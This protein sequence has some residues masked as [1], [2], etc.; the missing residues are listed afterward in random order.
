[1]S[2][3]KYFLRDDIY[4]ELLFGILVLTGPFMT[5]GLDSNSFVW[6]ISLTI[7]VCALIG[8]V[9][10]VWYCLKNKT[11]KKESSLTFAFLELLFPY[12]FALSALISDP[13]GKDT[14]ESLW[15]AAFLVILIVLELFIPDKKSCSENPL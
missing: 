13:S 15:F 4:A 12:S 7:A 5:I 9:A 2:K 8:L 14:R 6:H 1:M 3:I 10:R 11:S